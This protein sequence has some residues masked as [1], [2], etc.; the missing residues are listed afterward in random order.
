M[1]Q[2]QITPPQQGAA[3]LLAM[4]TAALVTMLASAGLWQQWRTVSVEIAERA[5]QQAHWLLLGAQDWAR[6]VL[7]EDGRNVGADHLGEPWAI[8][9]KEAR[10]S[11]FLAAS[12][13][14]VVEN[15][16]GLMDQVF[17]SGRITD[18]QSRLNL[19]NLVVNGELVDSEWQAWFRLYQLL[20]L[21]Q[22]ELEAWT[23]AYKA[24]QALV[25]ENDAP[26]APQRLEQLSWLGMSRASLAKLAP[27]IGLLPVA[28]PVNL[29]TAS[30]QVLA[31]VVPGLSVSNAQQWIA[32]RNTQAWDSLE[33]AQK[34]LGESASGLN[35]KQHSINSGYF[36][37]TG[38]LRL[39][40][41]TLIEKSLVRR[42]GID[43]Q[44]VW[45]ERRPLHSE[46]G[47]MVTVAAPC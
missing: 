44:T 40:S 5:S 18:M 12:P 37:V 3:L 1:K 19:R 16:D 34:K 9:L 4:L 13:A 39:D 17:L 38:Q 21:P 43:S 29:N 25:F 7:R 26:L 28:T 42:T 31:A 33:E 27:H 6:V 47:C 23:K 10:L 8:P 35:P 2:R 36:E 24:S 14:G 45:Q 22:A 41:V 46:P 11:S 15:T 20:G 30:A 32:K